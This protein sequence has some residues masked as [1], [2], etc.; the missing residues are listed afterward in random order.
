MPYLHQFVEYAFLRDVDSDG[1]LV[2]TCH[3]NLTDAI[4][5]TFID[6]SLF[7]HTSVVLICRPSPSEPTLLREYVYSHRYKPWGYMLPSC[8]FCGN[9]N[10]VAPIRNG[11]AK[12]R[13]MSCQRHEVG[14][15]ASQPAHVVMVREKLAPYDEGNTFCWRNMDI[16][17][18]WRSL[19]WSH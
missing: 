18:P 17:S 3:N 16:S 8:P 10:V 5:R 6:R 15:G 11:V 14:S 12:V 9:G 1:Y 2:N 19:Q 4:E 7:A 13:C